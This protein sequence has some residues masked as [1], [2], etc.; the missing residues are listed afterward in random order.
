MLRYLLMFG[1]C[2][3]TQVS[4]NVEE[5]AKARRNEILSSNQWAPLSQDGRDLGRSS[6][7]NAGPRGGKGPRGLKGER[8]RRGTRGWQGLNGANGQN[9][10]DGLIIGAAGATGA[11]L[12]GPQGTTGPTGPTGA[13]GPLFTQAAFGASL[14]GAAEVLLSGS[15]IVFD[16]VNFIGDGT[17]SPSTPPVATIQLPA[18]AAFYLVTYGVSLNPE[19]SFE[20]PYIAN[21]ELVLTDPPSG[22]VSVSGGAL[23]LAINELPL[24]PNL[25]SI[26]TLVAV[27]A[28]DTNVAPT[29]SVVYN[30]PVPIT[31]GGLGSDD[32]S[33]YITVIKLN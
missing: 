14:A 26:S 1:M 27:M 5:V 17:I 13:T 9:G 15:A 21:F 29:L 31:L 8:G 10:L 2:L 4:G 12:A 16:Q 23:T 11:V 18:E 20:I 30:S 7:E 25:N 19:Q 24:N 28:L 33:A 22:P 3:S 32:T 6:E